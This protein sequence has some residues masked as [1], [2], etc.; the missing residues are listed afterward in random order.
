MGI[1]S[2]GHIG[3]NFNYES[4]TRMAPPPEPDGGGNKGHLLKRAGF[5][6]DIRGAGRRLR[7][8]SVSA[9]VSRRYEWNKRLCGS[10]AI[11]T[12]RK[13]P[14]IELSATVLRFGFRGIE[15]PSPLIEF[16]S[17]RVQAPSVI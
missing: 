13:A 9:H 4:C 1:P 11:S 16:V 3:E 5:D 7:S 10:A 14:P 2:T 8:L 17:Q 6:V 15:A 12:A